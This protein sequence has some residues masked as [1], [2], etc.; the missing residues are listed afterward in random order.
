[1]P[2]GLRW[3]TAYA[4][5][6]PFTLC[7]LV[8]TKLLV[9]D[10]MMDFSKL[11]TRAPTGTARLFRRGVLAVIVLG[12]TAGLC[13]NI[14]ASVS[15][16]KA[17]GIFDAALTAPNISD[18]GPKQQLKAANDQVARGAQAG[19]LLFGFESLML[20]SIV[21]AIFLVGLI[22]ARRIHAALQASLQESSA[23][24]GAHAAAAAA[25]LQAIVEQGRALQLQVVSTCAAIFFS[26]L[27]RALYTTMF[28]VASAL[29]NSDLIC[30]VYSNRCSSCYNAPS[31]VLIWLLYTPSFHYSVVLLSGPLAMLVVLWGMTSGRA[32]AVMQESSRRRARDEQSAAMQENGRRFEWSEQ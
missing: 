19:A 6:F 11:D 1:M 10:R 26:F 20:V 15:F 24:A 12:S 25:Q 32:L 17:A 8:I 29:Q 23:L 27:L 18:S 13:G 31:H 30:P 4:L 14:A 9:L 22:S 21:V 3:L 5:T 2:Q 16:I 28:S 7:C